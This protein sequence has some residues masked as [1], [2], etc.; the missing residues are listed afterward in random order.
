[1]IQ[2]GGATPEQRIAYGYQRAT[3][4]SIDLPALK[5]LVGGVQKRITECPAKPAEDA[6][7]M[8]QG[9]TCSEASLDP[10]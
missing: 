3:F 10:A 2:H 1:M 8:A 5:Q 4:R 7:L 9:A 6:A